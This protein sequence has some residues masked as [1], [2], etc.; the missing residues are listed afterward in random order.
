[1]IRQRQWPRVRAGWLLAFL[2]LV[3]SPSSA[4]LLLS[5]ILSGPTS[6]WDGDGAVDSKLDE[7]VEIVNTGPFPES[8]DNLFLRDGTGTAFH[9]GFA[10]TLNPNE[11]LVVTG[12]DAVAWQAANAAGSSGLS[13]NNGG[14]TVELVRSDG[15]ETVIDTA[16]V[17]AHAA[18]DD[19]SM[20]RWS[21]G[22]WLLYDQ[23]TPYGGSVE[24][25]GTG[26]SPSPGAVNACR[27]SVPIR[28][29][30]FGAVKSRY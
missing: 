29:A 30:S 9:H 23:P 5:E 7:W 22:T 13:L 16:V 4:E 12:A 28:A 10:G 2:L 15:T 18:V 25:T 27:T 17:P 19:R 8:L 11:V 21:D 26:C 6:D 14:D 1:M 24:P 3:A 20:A